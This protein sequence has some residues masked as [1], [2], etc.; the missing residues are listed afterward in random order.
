MLMVITWPVDIYY[1]NN[2]KDVVWIYTHAILVDDIAVSLPL[3]INSN[4]LQISIGAKWW[5]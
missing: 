3:L 4:D 5:F 1:N 2:R